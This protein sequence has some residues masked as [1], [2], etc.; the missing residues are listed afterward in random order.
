MGQPILTTLST[1]IAINLLWNVKYNVQLNLATV[2]IKCIMLHLL[3]FKYL[4]PYH[5]YFSYKYCFLCN[6]FF[7]IALC[8]IFFNSQPYSFVWPNQ[9]TQFYHQFLTEVFSFIS[10]SYYYT[11]TITCYLNQPV[12][13]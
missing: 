13:L 2:L 9:A 12:L 11:L 10:F 6:K 5:W 7:R 3:Y 1:E 4:P 8:N